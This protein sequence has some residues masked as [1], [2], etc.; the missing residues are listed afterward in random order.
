MHDT[1][2][3]TLDTDDEVEPCQPKRRRYIPPP[4]S[5]SD[6]VIMYDTADSD[7]QEVRPP[8]DRQA[9]QAAAGQDAG[10][11]SGDDDDGFDDL[12]ITDVRGK[13]AT[14]DMPH[15]RPNCAHHRF[16]NGVDLSNRSHCDK[17][18]CYVCDVEASKCEFW[19][20]ALT[21]MPPPPSQATARRTT[22]TPLRAPPTSPSAGQPGRVTRRG[23]A[24]STWAP[25]APTLPASSP[26]V[27]RRSGRAGSRRSPGRRN[28]L[29][30]TRCLHWRRRR[31]C[32]V[33]WFSTGGPYR[34]RWSRCSSRCRWRRSSSC[35]SC[36]RA[37]RARSSGGG[38]C[39][40]GGTRGRARR[41]RGCRG[42]ARECRGSTPPSTQLGCRG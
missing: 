5:G 25:P 27:P 20:T 15:E 26:P 30:D 8:M 14:V 41:W 34:C 16:T 6:V 38:S 4:P 12:I 37:G 22:A 17:C 31:R 24:R 9:A 40:G 13:A 10:G 23:C 36:M 19:G 35:C 42:W 2:D 3:L 18:F 29:R 32:Q 1:I 7:V 28:L 39:G 11:G 33:T 21:P